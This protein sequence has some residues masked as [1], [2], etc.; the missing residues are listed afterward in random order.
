MTRPSDEH[1]PGLP[2][3][4]LERTENADIV[5][6]QTPE[7][8]DK[9]RT[10]ESATATPEQYLRR[11]QA[12]ESAFDTQTSGQITSFDDSES[13]PS[14]LFDSPTDSGDSAKRFEILDEVGRGGTGRVYAMRD[15]SLDRTI[16]VKFL[17]GKKT[18][19]AR[20]GIKNRFLHEARVTAGLQHPNIMPVYDI[21]VTGSGKLFFTMKKID[22]CTLGDAIR[23]EQ[24]EEPVAEELSSVE[25]KV[26]VFL[27]V[28]DAIAYAHHRGFVHQ[29]I[30]PDNIMLGEFGEVLV[31]DWGSAVRRRGRNDKLAKQLHGT[32]AF[33]SPEQARREDVDERSDIYCIGASLFH[34]LLLRHPTWAEDAEV[35]WEKKDRKTHV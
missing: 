10:D 16:A 5:P 14:A 29:D 9:T 34:S 24:R 30:K 33:M 22:G 15:H 19:T 21:G 12:S 35:F 18:N 28:C 27:K 31:L 11:T 2:E 4:A 17:K 23:A 32:P 20:A 7:A 6:L 8:L 3:D 1:K 25:G 13:V 26:R